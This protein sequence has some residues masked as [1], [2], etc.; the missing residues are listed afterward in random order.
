M[1]H[2]TLERAQDLVREMDTIRR[3][4]TKVS[5][6]SLVLVDGV[7]VLRYLPTDVV[8]DVVDR[9]QLAL[10]AEYERRFALFREL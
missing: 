10:E 9:L 4:S 3:M 1:D 6:R 2:R 7:R 8:Q 5:D